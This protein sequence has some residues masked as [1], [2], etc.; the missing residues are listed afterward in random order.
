MT[1]K[2]LRMAR[3]FREGKAVV[4]AAD[5]GVAF[6][7]VKGIEDLRRVVAASAVGGADAV[8]LNLGA[9]KHVCEEAA[10]RLAVIASLPLRKKVNYETLIETAV[11]AGVD[12]VKLM[13]FTNCPEEDLYVDALVDVANLCEE[14]GMPLMAEMYPREKN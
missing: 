12:A 8:M 6:G 2:T 1:G 14:W 11:K 4:I 3:I 10:G 9:V 13:V 5:H 7:P